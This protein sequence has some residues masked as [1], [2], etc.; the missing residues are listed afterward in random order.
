MP[1]SNLLP[2]ARPRRTRNSMHSHQ[3]THKHLPRP[4]HHNWR[5]PPRRPHQ[6]LG[7]ILPPTHTPLHT[8]QRPPPPH[9]H[10][11]TPTNTSYMHRPLSILPPT[12][13][14]HPNTRHLQ[15][16]TR[17]PRPR[18]HQ[19]QSLPTTETPHPTSHTQTHERHFLLPTHTISLPHSTTTPHTMERNNALNH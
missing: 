11:T 4:H 18:R 9:I 16:L 6:L 2:P 1:T 8:L 19:G 12:P 13:Q 7:Q 17:I 10:T 5:R 14:Q 15:Y 3:H